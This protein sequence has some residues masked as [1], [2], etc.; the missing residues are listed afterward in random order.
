LTIHLNPK[1]LSVCQKYRQKQCSFGKKGKGCEFSHPNVCF[2]FI[3]FGNK[4]YHKNG[5]SFKKDCK[6]MHPV[7]CK[8]YYKN[9]CFNKKCHKLHFGSNKPEISKPMGQDFPK[10][11]NF[12]AEQTGDFL[13]KK[14]LSSVLEALENRLLQ[15]MEGIMRTFQQ[16]TQPSQHSMHLPWQN[17]SQSYIQSQKNPPFLI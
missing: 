3:K 13:D 2:R 14:G 12:S 6:F 1:K 4:D 16:Q 7:V 8:A 17:M 5:C 15:Q 10:K 9:K 11:A